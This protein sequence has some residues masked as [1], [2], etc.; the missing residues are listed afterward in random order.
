MRGIILQD[1]CLSFASPEI[2]LKRVSSL[3]QESVW[4]VK[5]LT[6][7]AFPNRDASILASTFREQANSSCIPGMLSTSPHYLQ[8]L[9]DAD[10]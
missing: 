5:R 7:F 1:K 4:H 8:L 3:P 2:C 6:S 9:Q 10:F